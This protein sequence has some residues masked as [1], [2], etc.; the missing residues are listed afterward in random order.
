MPITYLKRSKKMKL[1]LKL[2][3]I[4]ALFAVIV[5]LVPNAYAGSANNSITVLYDAFGK[6][7]EMKKDWVFCLYRVRWKTYPL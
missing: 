5:M 6:S 3:H 7:S 2:R 1:K 4:V